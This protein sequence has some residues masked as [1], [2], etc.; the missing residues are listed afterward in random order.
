VIKLSGGPALPAGR[1]RW[2][3]S[4]L[5][6]ERSGRVVFVSHCLL[7]QNTRYLGAAWP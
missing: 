7:N 4:R 5:R 6:D 1:L 2:L 3:R